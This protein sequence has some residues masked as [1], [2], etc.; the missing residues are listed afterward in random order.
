MSSA[1]S[2]GETKKRESPGEPMTTIRSPRLSPLHKFDPMLLEGHKKV[3]SEYPF[4]HQRKPSKNKAINNGVPETIEED[5]KEEDSQPKY[6]RRSRFPE[7][8]DHNEFGKREK[9][10]KSEEGQK[11]RHGYARKPQLE[12]ITSQIYALPSA[13]VSETEEESQSS[14]S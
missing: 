4:K 10:F 12:D 6:V 7:M 13:Y 1:G 14:D 11:K 9:R 5:K 2:H 3:N 8:R